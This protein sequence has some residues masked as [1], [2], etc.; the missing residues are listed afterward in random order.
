M[1]EKLSGD[2]VF[3]F[4]Q[5]AASAATDTALGDMLTGTVVV[6]VALRGKAMQSELSVALLLC[7]FMRTM[8]AMMQRSL[9][10]HVAK[11]SRCHDRYP[12]RQLKCV[13]RG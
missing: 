13:C 11:T 10:V 4:R 3:R 5:R 7:V 6:E 9:D 1:Q 12:L 8:H 2:E